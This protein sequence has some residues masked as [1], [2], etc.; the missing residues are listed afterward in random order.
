MNTLKSLMDL[1]GGVFLVITGIVLLLL[2][3]VF[4]RIADNWFIKMG[5]FLF[6]LGLGMCGIIFGL[7]RIFILIKGLIGKSNQSEC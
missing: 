5:L 3:P 4:N 6:L 2:Y 7:R 1:L